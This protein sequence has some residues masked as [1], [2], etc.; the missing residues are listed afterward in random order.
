MNKCPHCNNQTENE[1]LCE[2]CIE[3]LWQVEMVREEWI[4]KQLE[5]SEHLW[6]MDM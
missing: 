4:E 5:E 3:E 2:V 6:Q 1:Y